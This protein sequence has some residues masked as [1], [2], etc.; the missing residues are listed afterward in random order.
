MNISLT[1]FLD[2][3]VTPSISRPAFVSDIKHREDYS[4]SI[5]YWRQLREGIISFH[6]N[7][8]NDKKELD[9]ILNSVTDLKK[10]DNYTNAVTK[11]KSFLGRKTIEWFQP[12]ANDWCH[13]ELSV[14]INPELGLV[15][16]GTGYIIKLYF[17]NAK[18]EKE[19]IAPVLS[20]MNQTLNQ[21]GAMAILDVQRK[22]LCTD[23]IALP[24]ITNV[25]EAEADYF[26]KMWETAL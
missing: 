10:T 19:K 2:F 15:I 17:R 9:Y 18:I 23:E 1:N 26:I 14:R 4:P 25:L 12:P 22:K 13:K 6:Q 16:D 11:Y 5:D 20:L 8:G 21:T 3:I 7:N 24:D